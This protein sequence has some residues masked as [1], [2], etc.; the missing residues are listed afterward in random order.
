MQCALGEV[1]A[2]RVSMCCALARRYRAYVLLKGAGSIVA[3][4]D[5]RWF[6]NASG[7]AGLASAGTGDVLTGLVTALLA[8]GWEPGPA[9]LGAVHLHGAAAD[10]LV[11]QGIGPVGMT[12]GE[13]AAA[14]RLLLNQWISAE[15]SARNP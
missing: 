1:Q 13:L 10:A 14:A 15:Q 8:Q 11:A 4:P 7:N 6:I 12:A 5:G 2:D 3:F 9:L